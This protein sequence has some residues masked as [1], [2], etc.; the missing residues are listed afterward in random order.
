MIRRYTIAPPLVPRPGDTFRVVAGVLE[1]RRNGSLVAFRALAELPYTPLAA[2]EVVG[3]PIQTLFVE[4]PE[5]AS[6][7]VSAVQ[8]NPDDSVE[9]FFSNG[10]S[11]QFVTVNDL[12]IAAD[13]VESDTALQNELIA[14]WRGRNPQF[15]QDQITGT[16]VVKNF[17][18]P[19]GQVAFGEV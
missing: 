10:T 17:T 3:G 14:L 4:K 8:F 7:A 15:N 12:H 5:M 2:P 9:V 19:F 13:M 1:Q 16:G 18:A 11:R 6:L